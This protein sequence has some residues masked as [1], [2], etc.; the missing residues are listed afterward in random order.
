VPAELERLI[1]VPE[2]RKPKAQTPIE[3]PLG[4]R[5]RE[6][7]LKMIISMAVDKYKYDPQAEKS[8]GVTRIRDAVEKA[9]FK[10][11]DDTIR[12]KLQEAENFLSI[13][14]SKDD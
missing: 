4:T 11:S 9:G 13:E 10:I 3:K 8:G 2:D 12:S 5:E 14:F 6:T 1:P 7:L